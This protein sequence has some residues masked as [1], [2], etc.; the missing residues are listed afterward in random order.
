MELGGKVM[1]TKSHLITCLALRAS[2]RQVCLAVKWPGISCPG[3]RAGQVPLTVTVEREERERERETGGLQVSLGAL[4]TFI[5]RSL[6][7]WDGSCFQMQWRKETQLLPVSPPGV[8]RPDVSATWAG[9]AAGGHLLTCRKIRID[10]DIL[11]LL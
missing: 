1:E 9:L 11:C 7:E 3:R 6:T 10:L 5:E 2:G 4:F 8:E